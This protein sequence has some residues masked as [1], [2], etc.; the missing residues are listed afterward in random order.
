MKRIT[1]LV[2]GMLLAVNVFVFALPAVANAQTTKAAVCEGVGLASD[3]T[4]VTTGG[5]DVGGIIKTVVQILSIIVGAVAVI[6]V[7]IGGLKYVTSNGDSSSISSAKNTIIY[8][9]V[10]LTIAL[11]AQVLVKFVIGKVAP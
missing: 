11:L 4:C 6:M 7:I 2:L 1:Q 10:G 9:L 5:S 3:G 8:A